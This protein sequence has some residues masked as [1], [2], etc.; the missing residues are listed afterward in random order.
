LEKLAAGKA[1]QNVTLFPK[2]D[3]PW[4]PDIGKQMVAAGLD[5]AGYTDANGGRWEMPALGYMQ[6]VGEH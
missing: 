1:V 3:C 5:A 2:I 6:M 4:I